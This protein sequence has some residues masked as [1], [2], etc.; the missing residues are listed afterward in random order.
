MKKL[1]VDGILESFDIESIDACK[2][3]PEMIKT[4]FVGQRRMD[5]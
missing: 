4:L 5:D 2:N 3:F 1:H